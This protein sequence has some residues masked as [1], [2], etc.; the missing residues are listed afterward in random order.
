VPNGIEL[1][2]ALI[3][4]QGV[5]AVW[6]PDGETVVL[7]A[8]SSGERHDDVAFLQDVARMFGRKAVGVK[9]GTSIKV[10]LVAV[11][12]PHSHELGL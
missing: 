4:Q 8:G 3:H 12:I 1:H 7:F 2:D 9:N 11:K 5:A 10:E 6:N